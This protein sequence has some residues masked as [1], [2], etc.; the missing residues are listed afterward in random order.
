M[1]FENNFTL[2]GKYNTGQSSNLDSFNS[3]SSN[4]VYNNNKFIS[5]TEEKE[6]F[7][8]TGGNF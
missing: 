6:N 7:Q 8:R 3:K 5:N 2:S 4:S 1:E